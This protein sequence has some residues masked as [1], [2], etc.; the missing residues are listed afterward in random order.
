MRHG[1]WW[2]EDDLDPLRLPEY[3]TAPFPSYVSLHTALHVRGPIEQ[4]PVI[5][6][7]ATLARTHRIDTKVATFS[8][9]HLAPEV[10]G[11]YDTAADGTKIATA[12]KALFD[13]AYLSPGRS[14]HFSHPPE[15][16]LPRGFRRAELARWLSRISSARQRTLTELALT[17]WLAQIDRPVA[18]R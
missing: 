1:A 15:L 12:E 7:V 10:S 9:H 11:G 16:E 4:I 14:R 6:Y 3:L 8:F 2:I 13:F 5:V 17:R 18:A